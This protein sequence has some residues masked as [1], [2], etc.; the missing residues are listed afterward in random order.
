MFTYT[1]NYHAK[2]KKYE[3]HMTPAG[4]HVVLADE[5]GKH[6]MN[7]WECYSNNWNAE[8]FDI[9]HYARTGAKFGDLKQIKEGM[10]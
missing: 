4:V 7:R 8:P 3:G 1:P 6:V 9:A 10:S 2:T 5:T